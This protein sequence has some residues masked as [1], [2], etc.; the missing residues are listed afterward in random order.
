MSKQELLNQINELEVK[1][2]HYSRTDW[3]AYEAVVAKLKDL[4]RKLLDIYTRE[5]ETFL[6]T[7]M[8]L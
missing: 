4:D 2:D 3:L 5:N 6:Q 7:T 8:T 1:A